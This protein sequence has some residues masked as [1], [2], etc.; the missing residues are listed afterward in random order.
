MDTNRRDSRRS[1]T[2]GMIIAA[3]VV[4]I[5]VIAFVACG[6]PE[7]EPLTSWNPSGTVKPVWH[8]SSMLADTSET[9]YETSSVVE[10][11][12]DISSPMAGFLPLLPD[13]DASSTFREIVLNLPSHMAR[14]YRG[15]N[16]AMEWWGVGGGLQQLQVSPRIQRSLFNGRSTRL[17][18]SIEKMLSD[19]NSGRAEAAALVTDLMATSDVTGPIAISSKLSEWLR[20][21]Q[22]RKENFHMGLFGAKAEYWGVTHSTQ[23]PPRL[24]SSLGCWFDE[25][26]QRYQRLESIGSIPFYVVILGRGADRVRS[27]MESLK[28]G[29]RELSDS[30]E[31]KQ[32]LVTIN[33]RDFDT[34]MSCEAGKRAGDG[35]LAN[36]FA[37]WVNESDHC[38]CR[39]SEKITIRC[40]PPK[41]LNSFQEVEAGWTRQSSSSNPTPEDTTARSLLPETILPWISESSLEFDISCED[42][43]EKVSEIR[44]RNEKRADLKLSLSVT[45]STAQADS[46][47]ID[48]DSWSTQRA[49]LDKTLHLDSFVDAIR[50][51]PDQYHITFPSVLYFSEQ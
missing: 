26:S 6:G 19:L 43:I 32:E 28:D 41:A 44:Q 16:V 4:I 29:V 27:V 15:A 8:G 20:S 40:D 22:V 5:L 35:S 38:A 36:Q 45:G 17:D 18:L 34:E 47:I 49:V 42:I 25:R 30:I 48:W 2:P 10:I 37:L 23:C 3:L 50:I 24:R 13:S 21:K 1:A 46:A 39:R 11:H 7:G 51:Q 12:L 14:E 31:V 33:T 9:I